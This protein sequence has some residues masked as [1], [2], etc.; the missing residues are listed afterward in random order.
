[1]LPPIAV[2]WP[3]GIYSEIEAIIKAH[4]ATISA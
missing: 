4:V 1:M 2:D 3:S